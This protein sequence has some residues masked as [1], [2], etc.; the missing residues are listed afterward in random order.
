MESDSR[1]WLNHYLYESKLQ[2]FVNDLLLTSYQVI[3]RPDLGYSPILTYLVLVNIHQSLGVKYSVNADNYRIMDIRY[4]NEL[5]WIYWTTVD[6][7]LKPNEHSYYFQF[8]VHM[9]YTV[10]KDTVWF[11]IGHVLN[12]HDTPPRQT[13]SSKCQP[14]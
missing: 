6:V 8:S 10:N 12:E 3:F 2:L 11:L 1:T 9:H 7:T 14:S 4:T 5:G 13:M